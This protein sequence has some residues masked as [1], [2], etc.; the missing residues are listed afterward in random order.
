MLA[1]DAW[2]PLA[3]IARPHG[4]RGE[5]RLRLFNRD[6]DLLLGLDEVLVRMPD[7]QEHEVTV[8]GARRANDAILMKLYSVDDRDDAD[9]LRGAS[10][11]ARRGDFPPLDE[12]EFY[13]CDVEGAQVVLALE[14]G[15]EREIGRVR[16]LR[17]YPTADVLVVEAAE[18][19]AA[20]E[21][22]LVAD[23][24]RSVDVGSSRVTLS[25]MTGVERE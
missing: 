5:L 8:D 4:V 12:G 9:A 20:W 24:V 10:V 21:I 7:G 15:G 1:E 14:E 13:V 16:G 22:P 18:G 17:N 6:S 25:T 23:V 19:G 11:C 2:V 3:E